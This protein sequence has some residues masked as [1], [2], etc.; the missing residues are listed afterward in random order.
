MPTRWSPTRWSLTKSPKFDRLEPE[1]IRPALT[2]L[3]FSNER[4]RL[5]IHSRS[6]SP[7]V[8]D[9]ENPMLHYALVFL[10]VAIIAGILG[11]GGIAGTAAGIAQVLFFVFLVLFLVGLVVGR[12]PVV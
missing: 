1:G 9:G 7:H 10:V 4:R 5:N 11:F 8:C 12:R 2:F 6:G 3:E